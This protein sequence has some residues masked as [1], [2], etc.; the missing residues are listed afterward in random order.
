MRG[1]FLQTRIST[2]IGDSGGEDVTSALRDTLS[3]PISGRLSGCCL[4]LHIV[5]HTWQAKSQYTDEEENI[6]SNAF[7]GT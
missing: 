6:M 2:N 1:T 3:R 4:R 5:S 7:Y